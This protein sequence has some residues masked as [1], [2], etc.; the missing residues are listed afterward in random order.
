MTSARRRWPLD[1]MPT[2]R[3]AAQAMNKP[4]PD[5]KRVAAAQAAFD[6]LPWPEATREE[7]VRRMTELLA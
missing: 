3:L 1:W 2:L 4:L 7:A 6:R 5:P